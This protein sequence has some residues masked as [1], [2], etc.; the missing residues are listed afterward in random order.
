MT[1]YHALVVRVSALTAI[2]RAMGNSLPPGAR[3]ATRIRLV[4][5][6]RQLAV[7]LAANDAERDILF[8]EFDT[9]TETFHREEL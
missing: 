8:R 2:V 3:E 7:E 6:R 4:D 1:G 9:L 5:R